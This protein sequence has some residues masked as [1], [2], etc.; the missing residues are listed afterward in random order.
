MERI[1][2]M[3]VPSLALIASGAP[4]DDDSRREIRVAEG[5]VRDHIRAPG[6]CHPALV[7]SVAEARRRGVR[8]LLL[9][10]TSEAR[11]LAGRLHTRVPIISSLAGRV[12]DPALPMGQVRVGGFGGAVKP[13]RGLIEIYAGEVGQRHGAGGQGQ[14]GHARPP[15]RR[16]WMGLK[17]MR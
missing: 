16:W 8:V 14:G 3:A 2:R 6:L 13:D 5:Q 10:G 11:A 17:P 9:G 4:L 12:P 1:A 7:R 15:I